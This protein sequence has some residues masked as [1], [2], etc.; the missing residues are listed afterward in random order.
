MGSFYKQD[1]LMEEVCQQHTR[2]IK[3]PFEGTP[4]EKTP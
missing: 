2:V 1:R 4:A 3:L